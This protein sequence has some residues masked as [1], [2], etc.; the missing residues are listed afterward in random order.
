MNLPYKSS[1][2][3][4]DDTFVM[5]IEYREEKDSLFT[6]NKRIPPPKKIKQTNKCK[7]GTNK[8]KGQPR[9]VLLSSKHAG[10][11]KKTQEIERKNHL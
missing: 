2:H 5:E 3:S 1:K 9:S 6:V 8:R 10:R 4:A 7:N 11:A